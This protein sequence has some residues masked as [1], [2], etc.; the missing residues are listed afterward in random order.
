MP[1]RSIHVC[2][3]VRKSDRMNA[4]ISETLKAR[5]LGLC[6]QHTRKFVYRSATPTLTPRN[7][8]KAKVCL[9]PTF[10]FNITN[11]TI[12]SVLVNFNN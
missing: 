1:S 3:S 2:L 8:H 5:G 10:F 4:E 11:L 7:G 9:G 6:T 12:L